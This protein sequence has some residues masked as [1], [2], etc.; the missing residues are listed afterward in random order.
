MTKIENLCVTIETNIDKML[1]GSIP[2]ISI[3]SH[4]IE[5]LECEINKDLTINPDALNVS[6][7]M[8]QIIKWFISNAQKQ[9][10]N[11]YY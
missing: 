6:I 7:F 4:S 3:Y 5:I 1:E 8:R 2:S 9:I 11:Y 10:G